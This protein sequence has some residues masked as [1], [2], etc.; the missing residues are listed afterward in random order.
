[1]IKRSSHGK[2]D[3]KDKLNVYE[4]WWHTHIF[5]PSKQEMDEQV[6]TAPFL[7]NSSVLLRSLDP[8]SVTVSSSVWS[9]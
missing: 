7:D 2:F 4:R 8:F 9:L 3:T 1:M 6:E 5:T